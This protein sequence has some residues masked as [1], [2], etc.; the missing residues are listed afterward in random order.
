MLVNGD[1]WSGGN[2]DCGFRR[3]GGERFTRIVHGRKGW[4]A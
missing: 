2:G 4:T 1:E 3:M